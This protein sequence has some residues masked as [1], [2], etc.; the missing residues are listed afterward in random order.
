MCAKP[1]LGGQADPL[2][3]NAHATWYRRAVPGSRMERF[4]VR[5]TL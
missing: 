5:D 2:A 4:P 1:L 3:G